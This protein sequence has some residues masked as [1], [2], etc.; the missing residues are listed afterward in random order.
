MKCY[1]CQSK[2]TQSLFEKLSF[3]FIK[4]L[5]CGFVFLKPKPG[6]FKILTS[7]YENGFFA[8]DKNYCGFSNYLLDKEIT[9][10][11][12]RRNL[13]KI[14][15]LKKRGKLLDVGCATGIFLETAQKESFEVFGVDS[16]SFAFIHLPQ[17]LKTRVQKTTVGKTKFPDKFF[18]LVTMWD[19]IEHLFDPRSELKRIRKF[20]KDDGLLVI[21][22]NDVESL[23]ARLWGK[24]WHFFAPPQ[25]L[26]YF[27]KSTLKKLL[28]HAGF[29][30]IHTAKWGKWIS[31]R[32]GLHLSRSINQNKLANF[33]YPL[34]AQNFL[35]RIPLYLNLGDSLTVFAK[36]LIE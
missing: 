24:N 23:W 6:L 34:A 1:L 20:L 12:M 30:I 32:H 19:L 9:A 7:Y 8:G 4:C 3:S 13:K 18:D 26:H 28:N 25:H 15:P 16:S 14:L 33:L 35:G 36:K 2:K 21:G 10:K 5:S 11:N 22:T 27:S 17:P 31:V 29:E